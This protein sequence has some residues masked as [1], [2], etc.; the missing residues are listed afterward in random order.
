MVDDLENSADIAGDVKT[1]VHTSKFGSQVLERMIDSR[2]FPDNQMGLRF[3]IA[4]AV[5]RG[6]ILPE[7]YKISYKDGLSWGTTGAD[8]HGQLRIFIE[9]IYLKGQ[10]KTH[11]EVY[12]IAEGLAEEGLKI[13]NEKMDSGE[14]ISQWLD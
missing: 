9:E 8:P 12:K 7:G 10:Q 5:S 2:Y 13:L 11:K 1:T 4:I 14:T 6:I 3:A